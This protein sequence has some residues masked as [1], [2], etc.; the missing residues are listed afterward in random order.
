MRIQQ[1][2]Y[3]GAFLTVNIWLIVIALVRVTL[4]SGKTVDVIWTLFFQFLEPNVAIIA[5]CFSAFRSLFVRHNSRK[6]A[7]PARPTPTLHQRLFRTSRRHH[8]ELDDLPSIPETTVDDVEIT[9]CQENRT[10]IAEFSN[11]DGPMKI[12]DDENRDDVISDI[13]VNVGCS[14]FIVTQELSESLDPVSQ[15]SSPELIMCI[16]IILTGYLSS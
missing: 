3:I 2:I 15:I 7:K 6:H 8:H 11:N 12:T 9:N 13:T 4:N 5:A 10:H 16:F 1:K 14:N